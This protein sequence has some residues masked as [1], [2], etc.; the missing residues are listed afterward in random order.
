MKKKKKNI[1]DKGKIKDLKKKIIKKGEKIEESPRQR[2]PGNKKP[3]LSSDSN[4]NENMDS[5]STSKK[6]I[7]DDNIYYKNTTFDIDNNN[8]ENSAS[9]KNTEKTKRKKHGL[10]ASFDVVILEKKPKKVNNLHTRKKSKDDNNRKI[11]ITGMNDI[12]V[13]N[14]NHQKD[15]EINPE[16][17]NIEFTQED[18]SEIDKKHKK[19]KKNKKTPGAEKEKNE[20]KKKERLIKIYKRACHLLRKAIRSFKKRNKT[21]EPDYELFRAFQKW[22]SIVFNKNK[23][24]EHNNYNEQKQKEQN[25]QNE[26]NKNIE[27][28]K[29]N[30]PKEY[31]EHK[32]HNKHDE[33]KD[34][35]L[36][37][38]KLEEEIKEKK[39]N[40]LKNLLNIINSHN[41]KIKGR[42]SEE[43]ENY[44][45]IKWCYNIWFNNTFDS[46]EEEE[47]NE[48][49]N[50]NIHAL[51]NDNMKNNINSE[52]KYSEEPENSEYKYSSIRNSLD[53]TEIINSN[54]NSNFNSNSE[55][56]K[57]DSKIKEDKKENSKNERKKKRHIEPESLLD[58][59][60][61][62]KK[63]KK[64][65][66]KKKKLSRNRNSNSINSFNS[67]SKKDSSEFENNLREELNDKIKKNLNNIIAYDKSKNDNKENEEKE[68][69]EKGK[70]EKEKYDTKIR[71]KNIPKKERGFADKNT[72]IE[73]NNKNNEIE[74]SKREKEIKNKNIQ[75][76]NPKEISKNEE[77]IFQK[78]KKEFPMNDGINI[79]TD[80]IKD[81][82]D[83]DIKEEEENPGVPKII[84]APP[85]V[86]ALMKKQGKTNI[87]LPSNNLRISYREFGKGNLEIVEP[88]ELVSSERLKLVKQNLKRNSTC[89]SDSF[90]KLIN[91]INSGPLTQSSYF[92]NEAFNLNSDITPKIQKEINKKLVPILE[93]K[94]E[95]LFD[96]KKYF[97]TWGTKANNLKPHEVNLN[98]RPE[99]KKI[100]NSPPVVFLTKSLEK[101]NKDRINNG[102]KNYEKENNENIDIKDEKKKNIVNNKIKE[103]NNENV[104]IENN[105]RINRNEINNRTNRNVI[106]NRIINIENK[107]DGKENE[108]AKIKENDEMIKIEV[109]YDEE[110]P[111][112]RNNINNIEKKEINPKERENNIKNIYKLTKEINRAN[113]NTFNIIKKFPSCNI[114]TIDY[115]N[116]LDNQNRK[117]KAYQLYLFYTLF[118]D[119]YNYFLKRNAFYK[120]KRGNKIFKDALNKNHI[121][122]Y[123]EH[124]ISC[125][126]DNDRYLAG[127][128]VCLN[129]NC[130]K[131]KNTLKNVLINYKFLKELNPIRYYFYLWYKNIFF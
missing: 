63:T 50:N 52:N 27:N 115:S 107:K 19:I 20:G 39:E 55:L 3:Q 120:W 74:N 47:Q 10:S 130:D 28:N 22:A 32:E 131:I 5:E 41:K 6:L 87:P 40:S 108:K 78:I 25:E 69:K 68:K 116:L 123:D 8:N 104:K 95:G 125:T 119:N 124:C 93:K 89:N 36:E 97:K 53:D 7:N 114:N 98:I 105:S 92:R 103:N 86:L 48:I 17:Q 30:E 118:N 129:C 44:N 37:V 67:S 42:L 70:E 14:G 111:T 58:I 101:D 31:N 13:Y 49:S 73:K 18:D 16:L 64:H 9:S 34:K 35:E 94:D 113:N 4:T 90:T 21:F 88:G 66:S 99:V 121:K 33:L 45:Y 29:N 23:H 51:I 71:N 83:K 11:N 82:E 100:S 110:M 15:D 77:S 91:T 109:N 102:N 84:Q 43:E 81:T 1:K 126:C 76:E 57:V 79:S 60:L 26:Q 59:D 2:K 127:Q 72:I 96:K 12:F 117:L 65:K 122:L 61:E 38:K 24:I 56:N 128:T 80:Y 46:K 62:D 106:N 54:I 75:K 112:N 85:Q